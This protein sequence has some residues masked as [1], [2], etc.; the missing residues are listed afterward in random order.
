MRRLFP[1][2]SLNLVAERNYRRLHDGLSE[3]EHRPLV[4]SIGGGDGGSGASALSDSS[5]DIVISDVALG[6]STHLAADAHQLP[7]DDGC[8]DGVVAQ[9]VLEHVLD[10]WV[11]VEE[12]HRVLKPNGLVYAETPFMQQVHMGRYDFTRF[13]ALGH[14]RL[15]RRFEQIDAGVAVGPG[16][17][18]GW[19]L[20][21]FLASFAPDVRS[22]R[23]L[24]AAGRVLFFWLRWFDRVLKTDAAMDAAAG[25]Y[26][27]GRR[28]DSTLSDRDLIAQYRGGIP[29]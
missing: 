25:F 11:C 17:A 29:L 23:L 8:F 27:L 26:F 12:I 28:S 7:F 15:F 18:L 21:Y 14:R 22:R 6:A 3:N 2:L 4:L 20:A 9:A 5:L 1:S 19:S 10:P 24:S 13:T 16:S